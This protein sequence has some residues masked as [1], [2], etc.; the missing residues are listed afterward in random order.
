M[1]WLNGRLRNADKSSGKAFQHV[2]AAQHSLDVWCAPQHMSIGP[3]TWQSICILEIGGS[4]E[5]KD[6]NPPFDVFDV[7]AGSL[8]SVGVAAPAF[9][10]A[11]IITMVK[12]LS[13]TAGSGSEYDVL[14]SPC[15]VE[16]WMYHP[17]EFDGMTLTGRIDW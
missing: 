12:F 10:S 9:C 8:R 11:H 7:E 6:L 13:S 16:I 15:R 1:K 4:M 3:R 14:W 2:K 17:D 5:I